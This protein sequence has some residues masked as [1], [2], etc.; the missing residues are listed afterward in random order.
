MMVFINHTAH[1]RFLAQF[2][3]EVFV[4]LMDNVSQAYLAGHIGLL[5]ETYILRHIFPA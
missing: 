1:L 4:L 3:G 5:S 2:D